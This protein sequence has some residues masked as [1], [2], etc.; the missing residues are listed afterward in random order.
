MLVFQHEPLE[1]P[2]SLGP[3]LPPG[4]RIVRAWEEP[5]PS[6][7]DALLVLGGGMSANDELA[8]LRDEIEFI[9]RC[10]AAGKPVLGLCLGSQ[11]LAKALGGSV[12]RAPRKE[13][14]FYR[15]RMLPKA[16]T[17]ALFAE[18]PADFVAFHWHGDA[19]SLPPGAVPLA[20][21]TLTPLQ[22]FRYGSRAWGAQF[23]PEMNLKLLRAFIETGS[24]DLD[25]AGVEP[26]SLLA[27]A[28]RELPRLAQISAEMFRRWLAL[29]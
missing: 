8:F 16:R 12:F 20:S 17:D 23:H 10:V 21:S 18:A 1:G 28:P 25:E 26:E 13:I 24:S 7:P 9:Q 2:G 11:L 5:I 3:L 19:F 15:V 29:A 14:G 6:E 22:A 4:T 27:A